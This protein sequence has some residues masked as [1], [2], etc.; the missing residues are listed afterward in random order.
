MSKRL[1]RSGTS[2]GANVNE[3]VLICV[4]LWTERKEENEAHLRHQA[5]PPSP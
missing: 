1:R 3:F 5:I 4:N 2:I